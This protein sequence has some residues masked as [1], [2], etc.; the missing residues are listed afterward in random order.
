MVG[1]EEEERK[2][3]EKGKK[4]KICTY[5]KIFSINSIINYSKVLDTHPKNSLAK[6]VLGG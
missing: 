4:K 1:W 2:E 5:L 3:K 6:K